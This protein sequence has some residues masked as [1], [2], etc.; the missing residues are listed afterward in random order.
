[1]TYFPGLFHSFIKYLTSINKYIL[2]CLF[3]FCQH[4]HENAVWLKAIDQAFHLFQEN[5][6]EDVLTTL[7]SITFYENVSMTNLRAIRINE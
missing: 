4:L 3:Q 1:M 7:V 2:F 5:L 6:R